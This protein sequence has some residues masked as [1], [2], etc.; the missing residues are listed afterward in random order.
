MVFI[1]FVNLMLIGTLANT[2]SPKKIL[3]QGKNRRDVG[4]LIEMKFKKQKLIS[5]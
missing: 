5:F 3:I 1:K 4:M 2:K